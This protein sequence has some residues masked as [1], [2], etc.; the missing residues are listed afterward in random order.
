M[1][2]VP[3]PYNS[4]REGYDGPRYSVIRVCAWGE[5]D[6]GG[7]L[8]L[9]TGYYDPAIH[10]TQRGLIT[11]L[12]VL[13]HIAHTEYNMVPPANTPPTTWPPIQAWIQC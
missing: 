11:E 1:C 12:I 3:V 6:K 2:D 7:S 10:T 9:S 13:G 5:V 8:L 4:E